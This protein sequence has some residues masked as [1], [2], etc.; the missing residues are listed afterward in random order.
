VDQAQAAG[1][2]GARVRAVP[3][4]LGAYPDGTTAPTVSDVSFGGGLNAA[5][6]ITVP[7]GADGKIA[8]HGDDL[9]AVPIPAPHVSLGVIGERR[10]P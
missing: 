2:A 9:G 10:G 5:N 6:M 1:R 3:R 4:F 8:T 7:L